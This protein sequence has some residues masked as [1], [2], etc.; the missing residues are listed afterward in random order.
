MADR[1]TGYIKAA[2]NH[3]GGTGCPETEGG[4]HYF[5]YIAFDRNNR[6][7]IDCGEDEL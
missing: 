6:I 5:A 7:C 3:E 2:C 4:P 1:M